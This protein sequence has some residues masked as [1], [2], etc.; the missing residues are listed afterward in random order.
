M[1][2]TPEQS[3]PAKYKY[4]IVRYSHFNV[5]PGATFVLT[6]DPWSYLFAYL[7]RKTKKSRS[8]NKQCYAR[9][10][11]YARL[12]KGFYTSSESVELP[13][14][15]TLVYY[16]FLNLMK[17]YI[18][19]KGVELGKQREHHGLSLEKSFSITIHSPPKV[20]SKTIFIFH[21]TSKHL[22]TSIT[23]KEVMTLKEVIAHIPE[24][25]ELAYTLGLLPDNK[26]RFVPVNIDF[27]VNDQ[28][29][30]VFTE[31]SYDKK[32]ET[33]IKNLLNRFYKGHINAYFKPGE[34]KDN[35]VVFRCKSNRRKSVSSSN[36]SRIYGNIQREYRKFNIWSILSRN[37]YKYYCN[38]SEPKYHQLCYVIIL[39]YY[40]GTVVRYKPQEMQTLLEG[41]MSPLVGEAITVCPKQFLYQML[42]LITNQICVVPY[43]LL[44]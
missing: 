25:H 13:T 32:S 3:Y 10:L 24:I 18:S 20:K 22:E 35:N 17:S 42:G 26:R 34:S 2:R 28:K 1:P 41:E 43:S 8:S 14:K 6:A 11:Y 39:M 27:L 40:L 19:A 38:L 31:L 23:T 30:K 37:G 16:G 5:N 15:A 9:S 36:W 4:Q 7:D 29:N 33:R 44:A 21:E 12:A